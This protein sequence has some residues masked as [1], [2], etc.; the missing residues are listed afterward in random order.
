[1]LL[2]YAARKLWHYII[3]SS[4]YTLYIV[5]SGLH[6]FLHV[7][8]AGKTGLSSQYLILGSHHN[9]PHQIMQP[10]SNY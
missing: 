1:M 9:T 6:T 4:M 2:I 8:G 3:K 7:A 10:K 5:N